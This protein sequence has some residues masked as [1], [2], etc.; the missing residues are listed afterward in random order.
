LCCII[1]DPSAGEPCGRQRAT[2]RFTPVQIIGEPAAP[3][4]PALIGV[5]KIELAN[6][7]RL[8]ITRA[9]DAVTVTAAV[10]PSGKGRLAERLSVRSRDYS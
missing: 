9:V 6:G 2:S 8:R 1:I 3:G 7:T 5:I 10:Y 4:L